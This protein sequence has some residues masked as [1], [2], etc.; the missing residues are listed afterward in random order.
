MSR[1]DMV[2]IASTRYVGGESKLTPMLSA[3]ARPDA[4]NQRDRQH[5][6][7]NKP[8]IIFDILFFIFELFSSNFGDEKLN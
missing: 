4:G 1:K 7:L 2:T 6:T 5:E 8:A 3:V